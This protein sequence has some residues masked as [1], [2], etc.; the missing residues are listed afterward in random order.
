MLLYACLDPSTVLVIIG[1]LAITIL[2]M[3]SYPLQSFPLRNSLDNIVSQTIV[4]VQEWRRS[5]V[6]PEAYGRI[7]YIIET[8]LICGASYCLAMVV[9]NLGVVRGVL[10]ASSANE[11]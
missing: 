9:T 7:R 3:L 2:V 8:L 6:E 5:P 10:S 4:A 11:H 1:Q